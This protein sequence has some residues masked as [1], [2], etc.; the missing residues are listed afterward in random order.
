LPDSGVIFK[1]AADPEGLLWPED[2]IRVASAKVSVYELA[3]AS[4]LPAIAYRDEEWSRLMFV[5]G[6]EPD[7]GH[8]NEPQT[9]RYRMDSETPLRLLIV[10]GR[11]TLLYGAEVGIDGRGVFMLCANDPRGLSW[12]LPSPLPIDLGPVGMGLVTVGEAVNVAE[13]PGLVYKAREWDPATTVDTFS[14]YY[15]TYY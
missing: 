10:D 8:W 3:E 1:R 4:G 6:T 9:L 11:P 14:I 5:R 2:Y 13:R 7:G 15:A 12:G